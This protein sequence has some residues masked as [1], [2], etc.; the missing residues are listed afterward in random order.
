MKLPAITNRDVKAFFLGVLF[1]MLLDLI[2]D[3]NG[4][5]QA[6]LDGYNAVRAE[7]LK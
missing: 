2:F 1:I 6:F 3:W 7:H 4:T 5:K